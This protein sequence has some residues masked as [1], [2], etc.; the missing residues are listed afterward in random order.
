MVTGYRI[1]RHAE[2]DRGETVSPNE[3]MNINITGY[4]I[5]SYTDTTVQDGYH[6]YYTVESV[7]LDTGNVSSPS[8]E[9]GVIIPLH[10][11]LAP[12]QLRLMNT[13]GGVLVQWTTSLDNSIKNIRILRAEKGGSMK[14]VI[15]LDPGTSE[16]VDK[17]VSPDKVYF[18]QVVSV[19]AQGR[20]SR[21]D[22]PLGIRTA[23]GR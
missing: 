12:G 6:Y 23:E 8:S 13:T 9:A 14:P 11:P 2:N 20:E 22:E 4:G 5:N 1:F 10:L 21:P 17:N 16:W 7:G 3:R 15:T 18:Y 19:D